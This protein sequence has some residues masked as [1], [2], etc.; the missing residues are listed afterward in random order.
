[1]QM[2]LFFTIDFVFIHYLA[3]QKYFME[4]AV[5][6]VPAAPVRKR[7]SH[8]AEMV[9]QLLYGESMVILKAKHNWLKIQ[10]L[11]DNYEGWLRN[12]LVTHIQ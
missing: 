4:F 3:P 7:S 10:S 11:H 2:K 12:N 5:C 9:N 6:V 1:M 8:K